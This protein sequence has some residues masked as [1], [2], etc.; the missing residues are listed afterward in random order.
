MNELK[1]EEIKYEKIEEDENIQKGD[2]ENNSNIKKFNFNSIY[3]I[4]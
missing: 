2:M 4:Y 3:I 1:F